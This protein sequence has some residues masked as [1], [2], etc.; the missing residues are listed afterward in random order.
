MSAHALVKVEVRPME[1]CTIH[2]FSDTE[3]AVYHHTGTPRF[4]ITADD[5]AWVLDNPEAAE[6]G[7]HGYGIVWTIHNL[8]G[9]EF[10]VVDG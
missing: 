8:V 4:T 9:M 6:Q 10:V 7:A 3:W 1:G 5:V 2:H